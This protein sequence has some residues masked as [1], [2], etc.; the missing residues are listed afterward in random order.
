MTKLPDALKQAVTLETLERAMEV[1]AR[2]SELGIRHVL[3]GGLAV[4]VHGHPRATSV[5]ARHFDSSNSAAQ[6]SHDLGA[7]IDP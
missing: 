5:C 3:I 2:L 6:L 7:L 4:G 1:S